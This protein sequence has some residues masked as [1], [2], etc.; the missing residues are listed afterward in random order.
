MMKIPTLIILFLCSI[1]C[2]GQE[3]D[4]NKATL[5]FLNKLPKVDNS[6]SNSKIN[7]IGKTIEDE[8]HD[9]WIYFVNEKYYID[10]QYNEHNLGTYKT[11]KIKGKMLIMFFDKQDKAISFMTAKDS[12]S[13]WV[14]Q[15]RYGKNETFSSVKKFAENQEVSIDRNEVK[16][17]NYYNE[18]VALYAIGKKLG[19]KNE[20]RK[21][22]LP[23][24]DSL[25]ISHDFAAVFANTK[26]SIYNIDKGILLK[27]D[28]KSFYKYSENYLQIIDLQNQMH[29]I[30]INGKL[31]KEPAVKRWAMGNDTESLYTK[32]TIGKHIVNATTTESPTPSYLKK[33]DAID[34]FRSVDYQLPKSFSKVVF[35]NNKKELIEEDYWYYVGFFTPLEPYFIIAKSK[36][37]FGLWN[38]REEKNILPFQYNL[39]VPKSTH[40]Y[41]YRRKLV[42]CY[43][44]IGT[45]PKYKSLDPYI[46]NLARFE[47]PNGKKGWVDRKGI[48][49]YD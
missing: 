33:R 39:I 25:I 35:V 23:E 27:D 42:T 24:C 38:L 26:K 49:Y 45:V 13:F 17:F 15:E 6:F 32:Y 46:E 3:Q 16:Q 31:S 1:L 5:D 47:Y 36:G 48:E 19:I 11:I 44:Y 10:K 43:P 34:R 12:N 21:F 40:L 4:I 7:V 20:G 2:F 8:D 28:V 9:Y 22:V 37:K 41:L 18:K 30:D 14:N 29:F